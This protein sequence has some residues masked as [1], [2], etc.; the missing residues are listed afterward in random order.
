MAAKGTNLSR[1]VVKAMGL[2]SGVQMLGIVCSVVRCKLVALWIG[3][4]GVGLFAIWNSALD[5]IN[6]AANLG[7]RTSSVRDISAEDARGDVGALA[8]VVSV[9]RRW[10]LW[11]G[12]AGALLTMALAPL[13]SRITFGD[14][15]HLWGFVVLSVCVLLASLMNGEHAILQGTSHL[16]QLAKASVSGTVAGLVI[17][18]PLYYFLRSDSVLPAIVVCSVCMAASA[19]IYRNRTCSRVSMSR[20][21]VWRRGSEFVRLGIFMTVGGMLAMVSNYVFVAYLNAEGGTA[22]VGYYQAGYTLANKYVGLVLSAL[23]M[24]YFPRLGK[25]AHSRIRLSLFA[26]QEINITLAVLTPVVMVMILLRQVVVHLL[27]SAEFSVILTCFTWM[28]V[29]MVLRAI[30]WCL[31]FVILARGDGRT[32]VVTETVSVALGFALNVVCYQRW[33]LDG[34]GL[35]F[36]VW[37]VAYNVIMCVVC[38]GKYRMRLHGSVWVNVAW[39]VA[40]TV[41]GAL[42]IEAGCTAAAVAL[43]A[44]SVIVGAVL[45]RR[46]LHA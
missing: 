1:V 45:M 5:M 4:V 26:S 13:L 20:S 37:Y 32:F 10:S 15:S 27:Y 42:S 38:L 41:G 2:F 40:V 23:S 29:G 44:L 25:V 39:A 30:S 28:L 3:P 33:G 18:I 22:T 24:E 21:E 35:S 14:D 46:H 16:A 7:I 17:S 31:S 12:L 6:S 11:L 19:Y 43:T 34:L 9:V 36:A 8:R